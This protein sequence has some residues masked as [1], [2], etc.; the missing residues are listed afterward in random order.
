M[1][2]SPQSLCSKWLLLLSNNEITKKLVTPRNA[3]KWLPTR[4]QIKPTLTICFSKNWMLFWVLH[5]FSNAANKIFNPVLLHDSELQDSFN[6]IYWKC[7]AC[8]HRYN[9]SHSSWLGGRFCS[10]GCSSINTE[11]IQALGGC[12][13]VLNYVGLR[14]G[15]QACSGL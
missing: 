8:T 10:S 1:S 5:F 7:P 11:T 6:G 13:S 14:Q 9:H 12:T 2:S 15:A 3:M 4:P